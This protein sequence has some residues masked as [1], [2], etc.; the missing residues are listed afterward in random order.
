[1]AERWG[2]G[3]DFDRDAVVDQAP[4]Q[5]LRELAHCLDDVD[6]SFWQWL[7]GP[8]SF[9]ADPSEEYLAMTALT[10]AVAAARDKLRSLKDSVIPNAGPAI[11]S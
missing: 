8:E 2:V 3:D 1:M 10:M 11:R 6:D 7:A 9:S 4:A 5:D